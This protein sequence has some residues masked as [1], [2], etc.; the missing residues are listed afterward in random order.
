VGIP[1]WMLGGRLRRAACVG[2]VA[3]FAL[4]ATAVAAPDCADYPQPRTVLS[5]LPQLESVI[6][7][8]AGHL[9]FVESG[10]GRLMKLAE[11]GAQPQVLLDGIDH[12]LGLAF[13]PRERLYLGY[14]GDGV[15]SQ[16]TRSGGLLRVD[17]RTGAYSVY[18]TG[19]DMANGV[20][21]GPDGAI[22]ASDD[23]GTQI[24]RVIDGQVTNDWATVVSANG[25]VVDSAGRWLYA[26]QT[27]QPA[28]IARV[29]IANP[30]HVETYVQA[31]P[32]DIAAGPDGM[33]RDEKDQ[34]YV[35][36]NGAGEVWRIDTQRR[37]CVLWHGPGYPDGPSAVA[38][39]NGT[40]R[41][42][43]TSLFVVTFDGNLIELPGVRA[44]R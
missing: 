9:Y 37:I 3:I 30:Q 5:G 41:F 18:A 6:S 31:A 32:E 7:D 16:V 27:F 11:P 4:P 20:A 28:A 39:G 13:D 25:L 17:P 19:M 35:A 23:F 34:L 29:E 2:I 24:H 43:A 38:F 10:A 12:P 14:G 33:T 22:Y 26:A 42:P 44:P 40:G 1:S 21:L 36:A 8:R 15:T